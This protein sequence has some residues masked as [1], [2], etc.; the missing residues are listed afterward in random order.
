[1][2]KGFNFYFVAGGRY[3]GGQEIAEVAARAIQGGIDI[4]QL[5]EKKMSRRELAD[6]GKK[7]SL[8]CREK[9]VIFIVNDDPYLAKDVSSDGVHLGQEDVKKYPIAKTREIL[10]EGKIIGLSTHSLEQV[11]KANCLDVDYIGFGPIF[12]TL[13][14]DYSIGTKDIPKALEISKKPVV[15]I[16]GINISN[17]EAILEMGAKNIAVIRAVAEAENIERRVGE[18]KAMMGKYRVYEN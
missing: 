2:I 13:T 17:A 18:F 5:R 3:S 1:M 15:F 6:E 14:K 16:G 12:P 8:L 7:L 9:N 4:L 11:E 10:G